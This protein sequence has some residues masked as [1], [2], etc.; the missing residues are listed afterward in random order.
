[1]ALKN[2][3]HIESGQLGY[4]VPW[5]KGCGL[6]GWCESDWNVM[7]NRLA[8]ISDTQRARFYA[9]PEEQIKEYLNQF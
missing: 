5:L 7:Y 4:L 9:I 1:M 8:G 2:P 3:K 6:V